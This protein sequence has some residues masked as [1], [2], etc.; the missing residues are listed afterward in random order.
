M[1]R[2]SGLVIRRSTVVGPLVL[3]VWSIPCITIHLSMY[4][5]ARVGGP[6]DIR[7]LRPSSSALSASA[8]APPPLAYYR[9]SNWSAETSLHQSPHED[10]VHNAVPWSAFPF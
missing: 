3:L 7:D 6:A 8:S 1:G 10:K 5:C 2:S 9:L 4:Y